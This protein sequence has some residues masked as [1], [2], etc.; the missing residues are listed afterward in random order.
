MDPK[1]LRLNILI[2]CSQP[3][4]S[5]TS[6]RYLLILWWSKCSSDDTVVIFL[7]G[8]ASLVSKEPQAE[9]LHLDGNWQAPGD[10]PDCL[11]GSVPGVWDSQDFPQTPGVKGIETLFQSLSDG[12]CLASIEQDRENVEL[13]LRIGAYMKS[14]DILL[15]EEEAIPCDSDASQYLSLTS[16]VMGYQRAEV[17]KVVHQIDILCYHLGHCG[18]M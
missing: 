14:P 17:H 9:G 13:H 12:P 8:R 6:N 16:S 4:G 11:V 2:N 15:E 10:S 5:W 7:R 18:K 3:C 1:V